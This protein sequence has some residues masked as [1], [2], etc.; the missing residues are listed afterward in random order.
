LFLEDD[1]T[2]IFTCAKVPLVTVN[3]FYDGN[4]TF[5]AHACYPDSPQK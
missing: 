4:S 3:G 5:K 1:L 2:L